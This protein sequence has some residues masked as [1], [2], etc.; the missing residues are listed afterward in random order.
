MTKCS[1]YGCWKRAT[2]L[3]HTMAP[4]G[5]WTDPPDLE[6]QFH[7]DVQTNDYWKAFVKQENKDE[8]DTH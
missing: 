1:G 8:A 7:M 6:C 3:W 2:C 4:T 5:E